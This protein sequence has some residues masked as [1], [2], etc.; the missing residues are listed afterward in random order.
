MSGLDLL[1]HIRNTPKTRALPV[2]MLTT[3][4]A[5]RDREQALLLGADAYLT[6]LNFQEKDLIRIVQRYLGV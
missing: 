1:E 5:D 2:I 6:K 4:A 3:L